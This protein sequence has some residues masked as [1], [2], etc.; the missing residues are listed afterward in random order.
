MR[1]TKAAVLASLGLS[2]SHVS[3]GG[4]ILQGAEAPDV[5][6]GC[7]SGWAELRRGDCV[8]ATGAEH[9]F[10]IIAVG[11]P[12][13]RHWFFYWHRLLPIR[14]FCANGAGEALTEFQ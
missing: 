4:G 7:R 8:W 10:I 9:I 2:R 6:A 12:A 14:K 3:A 1:F 13:E 11:L 5:G